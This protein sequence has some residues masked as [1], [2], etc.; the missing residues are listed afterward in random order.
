MRNEGVSVTFGLTS[1]S[2]SDSVVSGAKTG[3]DHWKI[4]GHLWYCN[5]AE[6]FI[7]GS[8]RLE[9]SQNLWRNFLRNSAKLRLERPGGIL[10]A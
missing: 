6:E 9:S 8:S 4:I 7:S 5:V 2:S 3:F 1:S 10:A